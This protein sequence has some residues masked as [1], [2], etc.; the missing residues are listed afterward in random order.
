MTDL[1]RLV[2]APADSSLSYVDRAFP[3]R[4]LVLHAT[5]PRDYHVGTPVLF[6]H[7]GVGPQ[8]QGPIGTDYWL[9]L[10]EEA[11]ILAISIQFPEASFPEHLW[12]HF[13]NLHDKD[14][15]PNR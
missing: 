3:D 5:R 14:G 4:P 12:Y 9:N 2:E 6:V 10:V 1:S 15:T 13:S 7:H 8:W 11:S